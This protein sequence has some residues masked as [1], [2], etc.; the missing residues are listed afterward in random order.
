MRDPI[1][2]VLVTGGFDPLH[3]GHIT[4]FKD[5]Q[6]LGDKLIVGVNSDAWLA[7]KKGKPFMSIVDR[8]SIIE[9]LHMVDHCLLYD[10]DD[11]SS[12]EAIKNVRALYPNAHIIFANGGD[13]TKDNIPELSHK[14]DNLS[15]VFGVGGENKKNSSSWMLEEW[16]NS[17][18][19]RPWGWYRVLIDKPGY[20][21]KELVIDPGKQLSMQ[22]HF[23]RN[24]HWYVLKGKCDIVTEYNGSIIKV[25]KHSNEEYIIGKNV[26][27]QGQNNY[28]ECCHILEV[29][30]GTE[31]VETD[32]E[33]RDA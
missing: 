3:S 29:Q 26:W 13:K 30:Y 1:N 11:G 17:K 24:E 33:R 32:I 23:N 8:V 12:I 31:C 25:I 5:A 16:K 15:F 7:R 9:S 10:D 21:V 2:I 4:Y 14:D 18:T 22:R 6:Q 28:D 20:K 19:T 27:H